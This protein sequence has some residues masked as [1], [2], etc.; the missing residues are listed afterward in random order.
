MVI[1]DPEIISLP[2]GAVTGVGSAESLAK[3]FS[4]IMNGQLISNNTL[5]ML[6]DPT[7]NTWHLEK[8]V[9]WPVAKGRGFFYEQHPIFPGVFTFGHP[10]YGG[11][12][13]A[14]D[15]KNKI[16]IAYI[17]NGLKTGSG[18]LCG[19]FTR[20]FKGMYQSIRR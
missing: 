19:T 13:V 2:M 14:L 6:K 4:L 16:T 11:Q 5:E 15:L 9:L 3:M 8:V 20:L 7:L 17:S 10:G 1:N 12:M 18:E